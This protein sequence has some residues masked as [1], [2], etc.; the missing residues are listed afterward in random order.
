MCDNA[1]DPGRVEKLRRFGQPAFLRR[2]R[3]YTAW[4]GEIAGHPVLVMSTAWGAF[5]ALR[6]GAVYDGPAHV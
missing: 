5:Y 4:L 3:E 6:W 1:G 2:N